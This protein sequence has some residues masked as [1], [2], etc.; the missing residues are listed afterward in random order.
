MIVDSPGPKNGEKEK[1]ELFFQDILLSMLNSGKPSDPWLPFDIGEEIILQKG[2]PTWQDTDRLPP[3]EPQKEPALIKVGKTDADTPFMQTRAPSGHGFNRNWV[4]ASYLFD[5]GTAIHACFEKV[6]WL[7]SKPLD[8]EELK[9]HLRVQDFHGKA[10]L[11]NILL[12]R[13]FP[14]NLR[15]SGGQEKFFPF[16]VIQAQTAPVGSRSSPNVHSW[17]LRPGRHGRLKEESTGWSS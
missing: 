1:V 5:R 15:R 7:D 16:E 4:P 2:D 13:I 11:K 9:E 6:E 10:T 14:P 17:R 12:H 3:M 8:E